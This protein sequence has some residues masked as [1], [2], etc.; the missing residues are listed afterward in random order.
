MIDVL[1]HSVPLLVFLGVLSTPYVEH[2]AMRSYRRQILHLQVL[3]F[4]TRPGDLILFNG[5]AKASTLQRSMTRAE[6]DHVAIV[7]PAHEGG[8]LQLLE[9][10]GDGVTLTPLVGLRLIVMLSFKNTTRK[11]KMMVFIVL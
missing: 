9:A 7:V 8:N 3:E 5:R 6:W 10:T 11:L 2:V 4:Y 1:Q